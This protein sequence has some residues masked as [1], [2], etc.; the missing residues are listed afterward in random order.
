MKSEFD[1][2]FENWVNKTCL[3]QNF[4]KWSIRAI[5]QKDLLTMKHK[6]AMQLAWGAAKQEKL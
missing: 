6:S 3:E 4:G 1:D 2:W 5:I